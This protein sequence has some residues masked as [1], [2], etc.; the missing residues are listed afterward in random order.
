M[1]REGII[2]SISEPIAQI[3][4]TDHTIASKILSTVME[5]FTK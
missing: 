1:S 5:A 3:I 2:L 4:G